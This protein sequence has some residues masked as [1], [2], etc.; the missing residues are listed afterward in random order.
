MLVGYTLCGDYNL[1]ENSWEIHS[2]GEAVQGRLDFHGLF[3]TAVRK[4][5][6]CACGAAVGDE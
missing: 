4:D 2:F 1:G 3:G 6:F 5:G